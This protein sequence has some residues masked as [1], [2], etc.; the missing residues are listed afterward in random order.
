MVA[1]RSLGWLEREVQNF[2]RKNKRHC[3]VKPTQLASGSHEITFMHL[4]QL[5]VAQEW[6]DWTSW[7][8]II[9]LFSLITFI[10]G[11]TAVAFLI[12]PHMTSNYPVH[13]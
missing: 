1:A 5:L 10:V 6:P 7:W 9:G 4:K 12:L 8:S 2:V 13:M 3:L 11:S